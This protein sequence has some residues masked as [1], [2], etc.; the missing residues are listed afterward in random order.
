M[1]FETVAEGH[2]QGLTAFHVSRC[3]LTN[4]RTLVWDKAAV[5]RKETA[6]EA[7]IGMIQC[8]KCSITNTMNG[9]TRMAWYR[10]AVCVVSSAIP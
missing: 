10:V 6:D 5:K 3:G 7:S 2:D 9:S 1:I 4:G 8:G